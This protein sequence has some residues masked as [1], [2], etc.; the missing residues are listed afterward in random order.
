MML[1]AAKRKIREDYK[2]NI[3]ETDQERIEELLR[4]A[5]EAEK[6]MKSLIVQGVRNNDGSYKLIFRKETHL[7]DN[8]PLPNK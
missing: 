4:T 1:E 8:A 2:Q 7:E 3:N 5:V 6:V